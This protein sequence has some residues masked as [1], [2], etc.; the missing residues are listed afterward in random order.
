MVAAAVE[1]ARAG[2]PDAVVLREVTRAV[3][4]V[5]NAAY[6]H[7][8]DREALLAAVRDESIS[9]LAQRMAEGMRQVRAGPRTPT[10]ARLRMR[11]VGQA[12]LTFA[13]EQ[14]GL[15]DTAFAAGDP[16]APREATA[17]ELTP[18]DLLQSALDGLV[19]A[20]VLAADRRA[21]VAHP[22][23]AAVHGMAT[24]LRGPLGSLSDHEKQRLEAQTLDFI[25]SALLADTAATGA[26]GAR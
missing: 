25:G 22:I 13:R 20:G 14:P 4:V 18:F 8:A 7:F 17:D 9:E 23:W 16:H 11:A 24:L 19:E 10:G 21:R 12:Y 1:L 6:R 26:T 2:G 5:P 3:G 15:F